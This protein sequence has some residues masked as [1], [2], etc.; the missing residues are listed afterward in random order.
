MAKKLSKEEKKKE[1][2]KLV[3]K[4]YELSTNVKA[5]GT[6]YDKARAIIGTDK[7]FDGEK[8]YEVTNQSGQ[9]LGTV[10]YD[11]KEAIEENKL[12]SYK[13]KND[14]EKRV[15]D[16]LVNATQSKSKENNNPVF[17]RYNIDPNKFEFSDF[18]KWAD[19]HNYKTKDLNSPDAVNYS[20][21]NYSITP[22]YEG[23]FLGFG[24]KK[25]TTEQEDKDMEFL[26]KFAI[27]KTDNFA[28]KT[29]DA[30]LYTTK[31]LVKNPVKTGTYLI[32]KASAGATG[33]L[34][35]TI[36]LVEAAPD[37]TIS[38]AAR[39]VGA[40][41]FANRLEQNVKDIWDRE[42]YAER[43]SKRADEEINDDKVKFVGNLVEN[44]GALV[45]AIATEVATAGAS[46]ALDTQIAS[47]VG[48]KTFKALSKVTNT[49]AGKILSNMTKPSQLVFQ[50]G[51]F[52]SSAS[53]AYRETGDV[54]KAMAYG[55]L[56]AI[57]E[58]FTE[59]IFGG[60]AGTDMGS[61]L[62]DFPITNKTTRKVIN[63]LT[64]GAEEV[65]M[66][67]GDTGIKRITGVDKNASLPTAKEVIESGV[68][69]ILLSGL[70]SAA[71]YPVN[72]SQT[73]KIANSL[74]VITNALNTEISD[75]K[76]KFVPLDKN[77][78]EKEIIERQGEI[79]DFA[80]EYA[81][82]LSGILTDPKTKTIS[83]TNAGEKL[84][85]LRE[86]V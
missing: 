65:I 19:E 32:N 14:E 57:A 41:D 13:P 61:S 26:R 76:L 45:P 50:S 23:G 21:T 66:A 42:T 83:T 31:E 22:K 30:T 49:K 35:N 34:E 33:V 78:S 10:S 3:K 24:G 85:S 8:T 48:G 62:I 71:T 68:S 39:L 29:V 6:K 38:K 67:Y 70:M 84:S 2:L 73:K 18:L 75:E 54:D 43:Q 53:N 60:F 79:E 16:G 36:K 40:D 12:D 52:G 58:G 44:A 46:P 9:V 77:A 64:E 72:K 74:N 47:L 56:T 1:L 4:D 80:K 5:E 82:A 51:V 86:E 20:P 7:V 59:Q 81:S 27:E 28:N 55:A 15:I 69:G 37:W 17:E 25:M 63:M 11:A